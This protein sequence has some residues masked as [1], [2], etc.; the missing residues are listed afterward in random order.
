MLV[1]FNFQLS[2]LIIYMN[3]LIDQTVQTEDSD[4]VILKYMDNDVLNLLKKRQL[5]KTE[6][7]CAL[8]ATFKALAALHDEDIVHMSTS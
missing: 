1:F 6:A 2:F 4:S 8:K 5:S 7:K 3:Q